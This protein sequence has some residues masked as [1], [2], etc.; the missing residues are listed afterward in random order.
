MPSF[1]QSSQDKLS[2]CE[3]DLQVLFENVVKDYD[4][5]ILCGH[6]DQATQDLYVSQGKSKTNWPHSK[7]NSYPSRAVDAAPYPIDWA[8]YDPDDPKQWAKRVARYYHFAGYVLGV[9]SRMGIRVRWGGDWDGDRDFTDQSFDD[10]VHF[11]LL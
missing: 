6:R 1:S 8:A 3:N 5:T 10:L 7:H 4:C 11:E 9:A 2:T